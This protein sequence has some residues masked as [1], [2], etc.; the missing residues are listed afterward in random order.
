MVRV[1]YTQH[2]NERVRDWVGLSTT[3]EWVRRSVNRRPNPVPASAARIPRWL[4]PLDAALWGLALTVA[5]IAR[6]DFDLGRVSWSRLA[7]AIAVVGAV[8]LVCGLANGLYRGRHRLTSLGEIR[9]LVVCA[10][11][12]ALA[13]WFLISR[14]G[15]PHLVPISAVLAAASYQLTGALG[16]RYGVTAWLEA[17]RRSPHERSHRLLIYGAGHSGEQAA[18]ALAQDPSS[19]LLPVGYLDDDRMKARLRLGKLPILGGRGDIARVAA[20]MKA[21]SLL[22]AMPSADQAR[23]VEVADEAQHAGLMVN[24]LPRLSDMLARGPVRAQDIRKVT[25]AD[26]LRRDVIRLDIER[27]AGY[28]RGQTVLVTGAGGSIGSG[29]CSTIQRFEPGRLVML[30]RSDNALSALESRL[31]PD[32]ERAVLLL[33][34]ITDPERLS[35]VFAEHR[36]D[37]VFHAAALKHL[38]FAEMYP[39]EAFNHNVLG[40]LNVLAAAAR[41]GAERVVNVSTD[42]AAESVSVLGNTKRIAEMLTSHFGSISRGVY[43]SVRFGNV[44]GSS[45]SVLPKFREQLERGQP[46]TVT[47]PDVTR[48]FM[49]PEEAVD[50]VL[51]AGALG[52]RGEVIVLDM[53]EPVKIVELAKRL[54]NELTPGRA[55][56]IR[57]VGLRPG[58][59]L[60]EQLIA[61]DE[62]IIDA[63]HELLRTIAVPPLDPSLL[64]ELMGER[65]PELL[66]KKLQSLAQGSGVPAEAQRAASASRN[67]ASNRSATDAAE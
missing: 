43:L 19:D 58:E 7:V 62:V 63:P 13:L 31:G 3:R 65:D 61:D 41:Y 53:G 14:L 50:L 49:V 26:F 18:R 16:A 51:Q 44:L 12:S 39:I 25:V 11:A 64:E 67:A 5:T 17:R 15:P 21:D 34:D 36:P 38:P 27:I 56:E 2:S 23:I 66:I 8:H 37:V 42:K 55:P 28:L 47:H 45:G 59:K 48:Y 60:Q 22:I 32:P 30:D 20:A 24:I 52:G 46:L 6:F 54:A 9:L 4:A 40:T 29:L 33:A 35:E 1:L 10:L 57:F